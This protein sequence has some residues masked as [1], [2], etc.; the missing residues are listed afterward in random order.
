M[1]LFHHF[2]I[3]KCEI[4]FID[5]QAPRIGVMDKTRFLGG[6]VEMCEGPD[7]GSMYWENGSRTWGWGMARSD[8][9]Q[10]VFFRR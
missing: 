1:M 2:A 3:T 7:S 4:H 6:M 8:L 9:G 10:G 5:C